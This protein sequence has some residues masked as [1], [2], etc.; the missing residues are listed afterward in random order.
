METKESYIKHINNMQKYINYLWE[1]ILICEIDKYEQVLDN[2]KNLHT[3]F[4][5]N[6]NNYTDLKDKINCYKVQEYS[7]NIEELICDFE[8][9]AHKEDYI[10]ACD[11]L[12]YKIEPILVKMLKM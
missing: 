1:I 4:I 6:S 5:R 8:K 7:E 11:I 3:G 9:L 10:S 2:I 12:K